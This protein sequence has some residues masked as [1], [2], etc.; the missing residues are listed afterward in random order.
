[1]AIRYLSHII[2][3]RYARTRIQTL[4]VEDKMQ[5]KGLTFLKEQKSPSP[6]PPTAFRLT[7]SSQTICQFDR[8]CAKSCMVSK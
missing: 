5:D 6:I 8:D 7:T 4:L 3:C 1:M 2:N